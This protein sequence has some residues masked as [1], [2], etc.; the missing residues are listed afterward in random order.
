MGER[1]RYA[2]FTGE[3]GAKGDRGE[4]GEGQGVRAGGLVVHG[5]GKYGQATDE[6]ND[7]LYIITDDWVSSH[8]HKTKQRKEMG[9][10]SPPVVRRKV[11][12]FFFKM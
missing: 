11:D 5:R 8:E 7:V 9:K 12:V 3:G 6:L 10:L 1:G 4:V 2:A